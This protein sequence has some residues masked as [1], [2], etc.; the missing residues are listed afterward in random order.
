MYLKSIA[1]AAILFATVSM[2]NALVLDCALKPNSDTLGYVTERYVLQYDEATGQ[3]L[4]S[5]ALILHFNDQPIS[6]KISED[7]SKKLVLTWAVMLTNST[8]QTTKML[9]RAAYFRADGAVIVRA[10]PSG[11]SNNFEAR[12]RCKKV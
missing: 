3:A 2:S 4:A 1:C 7:T 6:A 10:T 11:Y 8:G 9:F 5:D 12:G